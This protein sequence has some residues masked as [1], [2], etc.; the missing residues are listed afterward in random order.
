MTGTPRSPIP[1]TRPR[2]TS[3]RRRSRTRRGPQEACYKRTFLKEDP[4]GALIVNGV[5][6][7][8][9]ARGDPDHRR[10][11]PLR[12][13]RGQRHHHRAEYGFFGGDVATSPDV[14]SDLRRQ[15]RLPPRHQS[16]RARCSIPAIST[17]CK[18]IPDFN[19]TSDTRVEL[20]GV[21]KI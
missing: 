17:K 10:L 13:E 1:S 16:D 2:P 3:T 21:I 12:G 18:N 15:R 4:E 20:V 8:E 19:K 14:Q 6:Y 11:L 5:H 7:I 9:T